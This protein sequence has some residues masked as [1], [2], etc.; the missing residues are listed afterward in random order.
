MDQNKTNHGQHCD[1]T[2]Q[3]HSQLVKHVVPSLQGS[4]RSQICSE[5]IQKLCQPTL[6]F[7]RKCHQPWQSNTSWFEDMHPQVRN[8][9]TTLE[10]DAYGDLPLLFT[11]DRVRTGSPQNTMLMVNVFSA[12]GGEWAQ[13]REEKEESK[14]NMNFCSHAPLISSSYSSNTEHLPHVTHR[15]G[16]WGHKQSLQK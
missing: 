11:Q 8:L 4:L 2:S 16:Y 1:S 15:T 14:P 3:R 6:Y 9:S 13:H 12:F 5:S 7:C 10:V